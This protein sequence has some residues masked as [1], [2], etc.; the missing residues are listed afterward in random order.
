MGME[1][2]LFEVMISMGETP[3][4]SQEIADVANLKERYA[5]VTTHSHTTPTNHS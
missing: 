5:Y 3:Q 2:G 1:T 4:T